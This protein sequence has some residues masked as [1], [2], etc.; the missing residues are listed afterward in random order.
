[1]ILISA[2]FGGKEAILTHIKVEALET[3]VA[4]SANGTGFA[5]VAFCLM[6][7]RFGSYEAVEYG[8]PYH[9]LRLLFHPVEEMQSL[10]HVLS[11]SGLAETAPHRRLH[12]GASKRGQLTK[13]PGDLDAVV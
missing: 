1:M 6:P 10:D 13:H 7:G 2:P 12:V 5:N 4:E 8:Q 11:R 9:A 3:S